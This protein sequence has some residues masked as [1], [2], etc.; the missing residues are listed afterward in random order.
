ML[1]RLPRNCH[2][3]SAQAARGWLSIYKHIHRFVALPTMLLLEARS[4]ALDAL[5]TRTSSFVVAAANL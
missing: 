2:A 3:R 1:E 5:T 4:A